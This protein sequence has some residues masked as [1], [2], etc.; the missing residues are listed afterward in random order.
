MYKA[1][2]S[3]F[4]DYL[5]PFK[6]TFEQFEN[7]FVQRLKIDYSASVGAFEND[8]LVGFVFTSIGEY[9]G[10]KFAYNGGTGVIPGFRGKGI[11]L[12][13]YDLLLP[14]LRENNVKKSVL[15]VITTNQQAYKQYVKVGFVR[16]KLFHCYKLNEFI[17]KP[18]NADV[19]ITNVQKPDWPVYQECYTSNP[20]FLD[21]AAL[22]GNGSEQHS[23]LEARV[24]DQL[25]GFVIFQ[26]E[27]GRLTQLAV[28]AKYRRLGVASSLMNAMYKQSKNKQ[29][30]VVNISALDKPL[31]AF[32][33]AIG[34][35]NQLD[36]YEMQLDF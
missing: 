15:E 21:T 9:E 14:L 31:N 19:H 30:T 18:V 28:S 20:S 34:F 8:L 4:T 24:R 16:T 1:F 22:I 17:S 13:L 35:D 27:N 23:F 33:L 29:L 3:A 32:F 2:D 36:Q 10:E 6:L 26:S 7:K 11:T 5:V 12:Q 25:A